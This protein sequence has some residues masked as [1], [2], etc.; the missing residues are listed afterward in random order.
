MELKA[1]I[2]GLRLVKNRRSQIGYQRQII[3][4]TDLTHTPDNFNNVPIWRKNNWIRGNG[5]P[6]RNRDLWK[7]LYNHACALNVMPR[8][9][10]RE[11]NVMADSLAKQAAQNPTHDDFGF[12][13][14][15]VGSAKNSN[16]RCVTFFTDNCSDLEIRIYK[17]DGEVHKDG[18][19]KIR[20]RKIDDMGETMPEKYYA[21]TRPDIYNLLHRHGRYILET[22]NGWIVKILE[23]N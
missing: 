23:E 8:W 17:G 3:W 9:T 2:E 19:C 12:N 14:G 21:Y 11:N 4:Y 13:P 5:E 1:G 20:F 18:R 16:S 22:K 6:V 10:P 15:R 7:D